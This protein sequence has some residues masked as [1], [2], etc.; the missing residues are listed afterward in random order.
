M[1]EPEAGRARNHSAELKR[2]K[3]LDF[4]LLLSS[5]PVVQSNELKKK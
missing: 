4:Q 2:R 3:D 5:G 1:M